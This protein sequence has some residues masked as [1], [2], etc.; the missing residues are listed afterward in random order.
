MLGVGSKGGKFVIQGSDL[1]MVLPIHLPWSD[2]SDRQLDESR[3]I[4]YR[5]QQ[6]KT[7]SGSRLTH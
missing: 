6:S 1:V 4:S 7:T 5:I 3:V 2:R